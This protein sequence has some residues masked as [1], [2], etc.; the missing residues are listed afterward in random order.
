M[1]KREISE[2]EQREINIR[3]GRERGKTGRRGEE[4]KI[5]LEMKTGRISE[6]EY[7]GSKVRS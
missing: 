3:S 5:K 7:E 6:K 4:N 1:W 2:R